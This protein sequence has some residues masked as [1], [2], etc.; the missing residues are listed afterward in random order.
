MNLLWL[1]LLLPFSGGGSPQR[2]APPA[3]AVVRAGFVIGCWHSSGNAGPSVRESWL[4]ASDNVLV[5]TTIISAPGAL[6]EYRYLRI[7]SDASGALTLVVQSPGSLLQR[8]ALDAPPSG[9]TAGELNFRNDPAGGLQLSY[10]K[11]KG[12]RLLVRN[13]ISGAPV[14]IEMKK[15]DCAMR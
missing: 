9:S 13:P 8:L 10:K 2:P 1:L 3:P 11:A 5:G 4:R 12:D 7:E 15:N 14:E 6:A